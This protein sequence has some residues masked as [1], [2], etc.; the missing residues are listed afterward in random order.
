MHRGESKNV[1]FFH[2]VL[3]NIN[4]IINDPTKFFFSVT[5]FGASAGGAAMTYLM[6]SPIAKGTGVIGLIK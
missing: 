5:I 4:K 1:F 2:F 6:A 3:W